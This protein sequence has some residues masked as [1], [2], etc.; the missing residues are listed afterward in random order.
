[1]SA[2][3]AADRVLTDE[4]LATMARRP[5][6]RVGRHLLAGEV[7]E[8]A[9]VTA[10]LEA[11]LH[12]QI[13]RYTH[14]TSGLFAFLT[15]R[16]GAE[17]SAAALHATRG[18]FAVYPAVGAVHAELPPPMAGLVASAGEAD[19]YGTLVD[20]DTVLAHWRNLVDL[21]RDWISALLSEVYRRHGPDEL[22]AAHRHV[23]ER[24]MA[25]LMA[26]FDA[27]VEER[28]ERFVW[29]L[30]GHFSEL[31][32]TEEPSRFVISQHPCG[33]CGRQ[34][35]QGRDH[36]PLGLA[37][38][39][40]DHLITWGGRTTTIYRTHVPVWHV[41][42]AVE[43]IGVPWPVNLCPAGTTE[44]DCRILFYKDPLDPAALADVPGSLTLASLG[45]TPAPAG[46]AGSA[47]T[48]GPAV[49]AESRPAPASSFGASSRVAEPARR[50]P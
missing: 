6:D 5:R 1:M 4:Q 38:V 42:M 50:Q 41:A 9:E 22:E 26:G 15:E 21:H 35:A 8:A 37:V 17:G 24:T 7:A 33:T 14:W 36:E 12:G 27:P 20:L 13:D 18:F 23:G 30:L 39:A 25:N 44:P 10:R 28:L 2:A 3:R 40:D 34:A 48:A 32:I 31:T 43:R 19:P 49:G 16:H 11:E 45:P 47:H 46:P 29:L